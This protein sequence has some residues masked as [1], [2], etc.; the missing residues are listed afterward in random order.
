MCVQ[1]LADAK[2]AQLDQGSRPGEEYVEGLDVSVQN[3]DAVDVGNCT[4]QLE[5]EPLN[6]LYRGSTLRY[7]SPQAT[8]QILRLAS[9]TNHS[10]L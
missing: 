8:S 1:F 7:I 4:H 10:E 9:I 5:E 6:Y 2:I 3:G